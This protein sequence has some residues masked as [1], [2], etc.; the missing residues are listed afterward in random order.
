MTAPA[1]NRVDAFARERYAGNQL[2]VRVFAPFYGVPED[3]A[4]GSSNGCLAAYLAR[5]AYLGSGAVDIR[6]VPVAHGHLVR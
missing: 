5:H 1:L 6:V 4:T 2:A 3:P